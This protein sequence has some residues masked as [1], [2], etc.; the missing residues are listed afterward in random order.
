ML[1]S[2][3]H[4]APCAACRHLNNH[5]LISHRILAVVGFVI[6]CPLPGDQQSPAQPRDVGPRSLGVPRTG[7]SCM[8]RTGTSCTS[9]VCR[10]GLCHLFPGQDRAAGP[11]F[12][13]RLDSSSL[14]GLLTAKKVLMSLSLPGTLTN[15]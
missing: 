14:R 9:R 15:P 13:G 10:T 5:T 11:S 12:P 4:G 3:A 2:G 1:N 6:L 8:S 7:T